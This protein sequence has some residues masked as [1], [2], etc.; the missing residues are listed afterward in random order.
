MIYFKKDVIQFF[1]KKLH[2]MFMKYIV[3]YAAKVDLE[4]YVH[5]YDI[6]TYTN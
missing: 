3:K 2:S 6:H 1:K 4:F 5:S